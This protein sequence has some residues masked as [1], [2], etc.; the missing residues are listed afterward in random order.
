MSKQT[1][2]ALGGLVLVLGVL[3]FGYAFSMDVTVAT[4]YGADRVA[5]I[6][7]LSQQS[8]YQNA[9]GL[10]MVIGLMLLIGGNFVPSS[11]TGLSKNVDLTQNLSDQQKGYLVLGILAL[12]SCCVLYVLHVS[13]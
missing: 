6:H 2:Q 3:A 8:K 9:G 13:G 7:L 4:G 12:V 11:E 10:G 5:N 1:L